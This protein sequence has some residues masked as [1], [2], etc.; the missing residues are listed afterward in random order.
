MKFPYLKIPLFAIPERQFILKPVIPIRLINP[1][2]KT[3]TANLHGLIDS[4]ADVTIFSAEYGEAIGLKVE[5]GRVGKFSGIGEG[6]ITVYFH[7]VILDV[8]GHRWISEIGFT[9][10]PGV[11]AILGQVGF[12]EKFRIVFDYPKKII[13][14]T[15]K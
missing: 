1:K 6:R 15:P 13:E 5:K 7:E 8:G 9:Y 14:I 4:G 10:D 11:V 12:F 2:D 3:R